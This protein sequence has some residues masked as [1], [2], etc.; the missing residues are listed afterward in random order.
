MNENEE[1]KKAD[2]RF[3]KIEQKHKSNVEIRRKVFMKLS[4]IDPEDA[5]WFKSFCDK[6]ADGKQF[7]G[8]KV[9]RQ[10]MEKIE[11]LV[12]NILDQINHMTSRIDI[13]EN[14]LNQPKVEVEEPELVIPK[15]QGG[16]R[17][18]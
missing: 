1:F 4:D 6:H 8:I 3:D 14:I 7:L 15:T 10:V 17:K 16:G 9:M 18:K 5:Q 12:T 2:E 11:P 13:I